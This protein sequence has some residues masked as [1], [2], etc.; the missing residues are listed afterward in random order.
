MIWWLTSRH[1]ALTVPATLLTALLGIALGRTVLP[2]PTL[3]GRG[4]DFLLSALVTVLPAVLWLNG[5]GR[6][7]PETEAT[8]LR[9]VHR[10]D[11]ALAALLAATALAATGIAHVLATDDI[12][13]AVGRNIT[14]Y[15]AV[16]VLLGVCVG[17]RIAGPLVTGIPFVVG[18]A[19]RRGPFPEPWAVILHHG[20]SGRAFA[21]TLALMA[22]ACLVG[23][24]VRAGGR[25]L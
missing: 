6:T 1:A 20:Q 10:W 9:P 14:F 16:A 24:G 25:R 17:P 5:T 4:G 13:L 15:L 11:T 22:V 7:A 23:A 18:V 8:A 19:G 3:L 12:A 21:A 2:L